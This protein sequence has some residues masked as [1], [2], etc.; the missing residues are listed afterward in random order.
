[1]G[2]PS[3][4]DTNG[5][6]L[7]PWDFAVH[8][9]ERD[10]LGTQTL[11][12]WRAANPFHSEWAGHFKFPDKNTLPSGQKQDVEIIHLTSAEEL[13]LV[14]PGQTVMDYWEAKLHAL[15]D[16]YDSLD[17]VDRTIALVT[18]NACLELGSNDSLSIL[19]ARVVREYLRANPPATSGARGNT[20]VSIQTGVIRQALELSDPHDFS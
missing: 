19:V 18:V 6:P 4:F 20:G 15:V 2:Y 11:N 8:R 12:P 10:G 5:A 3:K 7:K 17:E 9:G 1:M 13:A 16:K 14:K